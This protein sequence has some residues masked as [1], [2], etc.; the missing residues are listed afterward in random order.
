[1]LSFLPPSVRGTR[2]AVG[3]TCMYPPPP[4]FCLPTVP[5]HEAT[6]GNGEGGVRDFDGLDPEAAGSHV[7][8]IRIRTTLGLMYEDSVL[9]MD[10]SE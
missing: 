1:L 9:R 8:K 2:G 3:E 6:N 7:A 4:G 5:T 10:L